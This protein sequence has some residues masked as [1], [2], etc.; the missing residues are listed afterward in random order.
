[1]YKA[2]LNGTPIA[3]IDNLMELTNA[4]YNALAV[5]KSQEDDGYDVVL[6]ESL[7]IPDV[8]DLT[9]VGYQVFKVFATNGRLVKTNLV[10]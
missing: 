1:M 8:R 2:T 10:E 3:V 7:V 6:G 9:P 5:A 4:E